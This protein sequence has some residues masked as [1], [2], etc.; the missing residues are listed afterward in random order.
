VKESDLKPFETASFIKY[1]DGKKFRTDIAYR[2]A[3]IE[4]VRIAHHD[5]VEFDPETFNMISTYKVYSIY[6]RL[7]FP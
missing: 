2:T 7:L 6:R 1:F 3:L 5:G 4:A